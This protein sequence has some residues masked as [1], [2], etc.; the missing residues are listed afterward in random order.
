MI[1][2]L[3][4]TLRAILK[5]SELPEPLHSVEIVF[6]R[7]DDKFNPV[8]TTVDLFLYDIRENVE[9]RSN[10]PRTERKDGQVIIHRPPL[11]VACSYLI[12]A[13]PVSGP[14]L[15]LQDL[16]LQEHRLLS[17]ILNVFSRYPMIPE[18]FLQGGLKGQEPP[19]PMITA[20]TEGFKNP[21]E[22][23][24]A[25]GNKMR[26][27]LTLTA[28]ITLETFAPESAPMVITELI[29]LGKRTSPEEEEISPVTREEFFRICGRVTDAANKPVKNATVMLIELGIV[30]TT[31]NDGRYSLGPMKSNAY[32]LR[33]QS[34]T[35]A[36]K[37]FNITVPALCS[38]TV[39]PVC[40]DYNLKLV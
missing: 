4:Q 32:K 21:A 11:R 27:S 24:T 23:W 28:T 39:P 14:D 35:A 31:D 7:P 40:S 5:D 37:E 3:S 17:Q 2:D 29:R 22:F 16:P 10:E 36:P 34:G 13:W 19:L 18:K 25:I 20:Q 15:P 6:D 26:P 30:T 33:V 12:T 8:Q 1:R 9:L 38:N